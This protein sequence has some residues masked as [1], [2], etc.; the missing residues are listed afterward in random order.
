M[1]ND[2]HRSQ[3]ILCQTVTAEWF[4]GQRGGL[5]TGSKLRHTHGW[6][7]CRAIGCSRLV[8]GL[9]VSSPVDGE[10]ADGSASGI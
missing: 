8:A 4:G 3:P 10:L 7:R 6:L 1:V 5:L 9:V 2:L